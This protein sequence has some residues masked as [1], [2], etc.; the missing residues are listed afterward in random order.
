VSFIKELLQQLEGKKSYILAGVIAI[1]TFAK[2]V[3][4][5]SD[6]EFQTLIGFLGAGSIV[7]IRSAISKLE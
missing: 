1:A 2:L 4:W 3:G 5:I 6:S 7:T